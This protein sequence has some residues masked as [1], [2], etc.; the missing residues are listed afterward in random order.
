MRTASGIP[1]PQLEILLGGAGWVAGSL[2]F[3]AGGG[4]LV[5]AAGLLVTGWLFIT[6]RRRQGLGARLDRGLRARVLRLVVVV[7]VV[8]VVVGVGL[9]LIGQGWGELTVPVGA[10]VVGA[11]L[12]ALSSLLGERSFV[13]V[14][15]LLVV[16]GAVG[17]LLA[18][19]TGGAAMP[20]GVVGIG[21]AV[22]LWVAGVRRLGLVAELRERVGR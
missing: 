12:C 10:V 4:T 17:A 13:A 3:G 8:L 16:L 5:M 19:N 2:G 14:G 9:P 22:A 15:G 18:L 7:G 1:L 21:G 11:G 20:L 6:V